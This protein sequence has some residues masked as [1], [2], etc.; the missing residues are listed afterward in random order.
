MRNPLILESGQYKMDL[1]HFKEAVKG[2]KLFILCNPHNPG[3]RVW[4]KEELEAVAEIC[5]ESGT[6]VISDEIHADLTLKGYTHTPFA[7]I[8][9]SQNE[10][11]NIHV[12][13]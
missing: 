1:D 13:K 9:E 2:C 11:Y 12:T 5:Y 10:L 7:K 3:G 4:T 6:M 8:S